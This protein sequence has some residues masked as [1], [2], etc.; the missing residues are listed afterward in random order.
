MLACADVC[1]RMLVFAWQVR[2]SVV[3]MATMPCTRMLTYADVCK[4][5][6]C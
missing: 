5:G 1:W 3:C 6:V 2:N 4:Y